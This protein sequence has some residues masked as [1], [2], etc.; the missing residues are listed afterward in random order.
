MP[1]P[2]GVLAWTLGAG[3]LHAAVPFQLSRPGGRARPAST[4]PAVRGAGLVT[5]AAGGAL[6]AW[7]F[8]AHYQQAPQGWPLESGLTP[9]YLLRQGPYRLIRNPMYAGE[10]IAWAGWGLVYARPA[11]WAGLAIMCP[12][13]AATVRWE[14]RRLLRRFGDDYR[15]YLAE[16]PRWVPGNT[17]RRRAR[18]RRFRRHFAPQSS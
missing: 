7:A 5:V 17:S 2:V 6:M 18:V 14:E 15:A 11:V 9:G 8:A 12:G 1:R 13:M 16:V 4:A 3:A 10:A